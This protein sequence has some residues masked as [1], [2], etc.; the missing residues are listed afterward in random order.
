MLAKIVINLLL[1]GTCK[2]W[3]FQKIGAYDA[4]KNCD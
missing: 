4:C 2:N 1:I 3:Y